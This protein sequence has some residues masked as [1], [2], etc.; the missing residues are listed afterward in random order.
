MRPFLITVLLFTGLS[1]AVIGC[2]KPSVM[3]APLSEAAPQ[4][5]LVRDAKSGP[6]FA[7]LSLKLIDE[8]TSKPIV[9]A[10]VIPMCMGGTP[11]ETNTYFTDSE[12]TA[13]VMVYAAI[14]SLNI[15]AAG[16]ETTGASTRTNKAVFKLKRLHSPIQ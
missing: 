16:Y 11:Y 8:Q 4:S 5:N 15:K 12:G 14:N 7:E 10:R 9:G 3:S 2:S 1:L 6:E 13:R